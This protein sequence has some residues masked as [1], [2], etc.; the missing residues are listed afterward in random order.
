MGLL[1][2][3]VNSMLVRQVR[4]PEFDSR[5]K[6]KTIYTIENNNNKRDLAIKEYI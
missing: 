2:V 1:S 5:N 6:Y 4:G 3:M